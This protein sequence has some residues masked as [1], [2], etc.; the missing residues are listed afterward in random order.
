[1]AQN[2]QKIAL[3]ES[4][5]FSHKRGKIRQ[6][7]IITLAPFQYHA[8]NF[9]SADVNSRSLIVNME[10]TNVDANP[11]TGSEVPK[12]ETPPPPYEV[13]ATSDFTTTTPSLYL[14]TYIVPR[15]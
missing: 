2:G 13:R 3:Q 12:P 15:L 6:K 7:V 1:L 10:E 8:T 14:H 11:A 5:N 9:F 4:S